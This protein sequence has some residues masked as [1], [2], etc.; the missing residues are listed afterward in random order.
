MTL[1][2]KDVS[3]NAISLSQ[4][5]WYAVRT[6]NSSADGI[7]DLLKTF[8]QELLVEQLR[9]DAAKKAFWINL[10]NAAVQWLLVRHPEYF[11][12]KDRFFWK[13]YFIVA[14]HAVSFDDIEHGMLRHSKIKWAMGYINKCFPDNF[15]KD[16]RVSQL[17]YRIHFALNCGARSCPAI[18]FYEPEIIE[19][20]LDLA[21]KNYLQNETEYDHQRDILYLPKLLK[22]YGADFGGKKGIIKMLTNYRI[23]Q[24][25]KKP[26]V[27][28]KRYDWTVTLKNYMS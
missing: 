17:D 14:Q 5:F 2:Q 13:K 10:Y 20:Q 23:M 18:T 8:N 28:F 12:H 25:D 27:S 22:W 26:R 9:G 21:T 11:H 15:E 3:A 24:A 16:F 6:E 7:L 19:N 4:R 1:V